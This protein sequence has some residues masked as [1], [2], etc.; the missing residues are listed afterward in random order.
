MANDKWDSPASSPNPQG[1]LDVLARVFDRLADQEPNATYR[2]Q[3]RQEAKRY[4]EL[5]E[6][7]RSPQSPAPGSPTTRT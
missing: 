4:R 6:K 5:A 3:R 7:E 2:W 1:P